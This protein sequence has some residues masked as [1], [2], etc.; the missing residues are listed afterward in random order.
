MKAAIQTVGVL[1][2]LLTVALVVTL[3]SGVPLAAVLGF[4][5]QWTTIIFVLATL[6][7]TG[8]WLATEPDDLVKLIRTSVAKVQERRTARTKQKALVAAEADELLRKEGVVLT[9]EQ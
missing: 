8:M 2:V 9:D 6:L 5:L 4:A 1:L 3:I 7:V